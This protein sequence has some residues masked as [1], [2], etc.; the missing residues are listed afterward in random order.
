M[1]IKRNIDDIQDYHQ[2][3]HKNFE[4]YKKDLIKQS[5]TKKCKIAYYTIPPKKSN[6]PY[7]HHLQSEEIFYILSG[8]GL[9][10][11]P[12]GDISVSTGDVIYFPANEEGSH[13]LTNISDSEMLIY[14]DFDTHDSVDVCFYPEKNKIG[15]W[16][17]GW[18]QVHKIDA[19]ID[20][21][22]GE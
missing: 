20:Y 15:V 2:N 11:T 13:K 1:I 8:E 16:G 14:L 5:E 19:R 17:D 22:D 10:K 7:H 18:G 4:Y 3:K 6:Y 12:D 21:Y 9:V